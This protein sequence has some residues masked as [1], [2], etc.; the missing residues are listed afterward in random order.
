MVANTKILLFTFFEI[1]FFVIITL[2][3]F[4]N[5]F[6]YA[7]IALELLTMATLGFFITAGYSAV[8]QSILARSVIILAVAAAESSIGLALVIRM[9]KIKQQNIKIKK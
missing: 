7:L 5:N 8:D 4:R 1:F 9:F 2:M 3:F 6:L